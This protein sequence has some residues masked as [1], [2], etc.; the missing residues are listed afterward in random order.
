MVYNFFYIL[1]NNVERDFY[2]YEYLSILSLIHTQEDYNIIIYKINNLQGKFYNLLKKN[3]KI[4]YRDINIYV[5]T[6]NDKS[7]NYNNFKY[8]LVHTIGGIFVDFNVIFISSMKDIFS[9]Y[10]FNYN[11]IIIGGSNN[12]YFLKD[13]KTFNK[14]TNLESCI[15]HYNNKFIEYYK[16]NDSEVE[17]INSVNEE[18]MSKEITDWNFNK[19]FEI[20]ENKKFIIFDFDETYLHSLQN[21][22]HNNSIQQI[23]NKIY[24]TILNLLQIYI[25]SYKNSNL[26]K[27]DINKYIEHNLLTKKSIKYINNI[28]HIYWI[29]LDSSIKR[30]EKM[31]SI[32]NNIDV[33]STRI[34]AINGISEELDI[35][36][37]YFQKNE[38]Y[39]Y[40]NN[41][42]IE[43]AVILSHLKAL[44]E[45]NK[46]YTHNIQNNNVSLICEDD[47]SLEFI[48][49]WTTNLEKI[50]NN[51]PED[52]EI[53]MLGYFTLNINFVSD[54]RKWDNDWSALSYLINHKSLY[55]LNEIKKDNKYKTF[56]DVMAA[57]NYLF[58]IFNTYVYKYPYFTF[59]KNNESTIHK[60]HLQYHSIYKN[61]NYVIL[62]NNV[63]YL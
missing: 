63:Q 57:D 32:L 10:L 2:Y 4:S 19:Y 56:N 20:I 27:T 50:I 49:N 36:N 16:I 53:I 9:K 60:D 17:I 24:I 11:E 45:I 37:T 6:F 42:N 33:L 39:I 51:A 52:W 58:R 48:P 46:N 35:K 59:P 38:G 14:D 44:E 47:L 55:K 61:I 30:K 41:T 26:T 62:N 21:T 5:D 23:S 54:Y 28:D 29:N 8:S 7:H 25:L 3:S 31:D 34:K 40:P 15:K 13:I 22:I 12:N 43:Y 1:K 18:I